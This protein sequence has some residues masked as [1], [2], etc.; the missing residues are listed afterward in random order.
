MILDAGEFISDPNVRTILIVILIISLF[1]L[2][3]DIM[4]R[5]LYVH[6]K[7]KAEHIAK[8]M[9]RIETPIILMIVVLGLQIIVSKLLRDYAQIQNALNK[10]IGSIIILLIA[11]ILM[12]I[13]DMILERWSTHIVRTKGNQAYEGMV[14]LAK[15]I[16]NILLCFI[17]LIFILQ[18]WGVSITALIASLGI[19]GVLLGFAFRDAFNH[20]FAGISMILDDSFR[21]GELIEFPDGERGYIIE[22]NMRST[23]I[24]NLDGMILTI[25]NGSMANLRLKNYARPNRTIRVRQAIS[26]PIGSDITKVEKLLLDVLD[27]KDGVLDYP[28][29][30]ILFKSVIRDFLEFE[31][32]FYINDYHDKYASELKSEVL[33]EAYVSVMNNDIKLGGTEQISEKTELPVKSKNK[34]RLKNV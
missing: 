30:V 11:Y 6:F 26:V 24:R 31:M 9:L 22:M 28:K 14:P 33:K 23:K 34:K 16:I 13:S 17:A 20:I 10:L 32:D 5:R 29:P 25:P 7:N 15:S 1:A 27:E 4:R 18:L 21:K 2:G 3:V 12:L 8:K 19:V